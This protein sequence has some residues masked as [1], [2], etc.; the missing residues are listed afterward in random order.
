M[1]NKTVFLVCFTAAM[2]GLVFGI[3]IGVIAQAKDFIKQDL[4]V[5]DTVISWVVGSM[6]GGATAGAMVSGILTRRLGRKVSLLLSGICFVLGS[7]FCAISTS[8][9]MLIVSRIIVGLSVGIASFTAPLYLSEVAPKSIRGTMITMYQLLITAGI[10]ASFLINTLIRNLTFT[11]AEGQN[12]ADFLITDVSISWRTML[13]V[14]LIPSSIF[15]LGVLFL[16]R[17]PR[18]LISVGRHQE[19]LTV[20]KKIRNSDEEADSEAREWG[21]CDEILDEEVTKQAMN[22]IH[23]DFTNSIIKEMGLPTFT[24]V[25]P[26]DNDSEGAPAKG[27]LQK[28]VDAIKGLFHNEPAK[29]LSNK[30]KKVFKNVCDLLKVEDIEVTD[31]KVTLTEDQMQTVEDQLAKQATDL[32]TANSAKATAE[33]QVT[34]LQTKLDKAQEDIKNLKQT[35]GGD[36]QEHAGQDEDETA[37]DFNAARALYNAVS[38]ENI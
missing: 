18:W 11:G 4:Q 2:A 15:L 12:P 27:V 7:L 30:M 38:G 14:T 34:D 3:D 31:S 29:N 5:D 19:A 24:S 36:Q 26:D 33:A 10:L 28:T 17:S 13:F 6:M 8:G 16:P 32:E 37:V 22:S 23:N 20:L 21:L 1:Q 9:A 35:A 25:I